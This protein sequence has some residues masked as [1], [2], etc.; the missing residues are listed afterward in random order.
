MDIDNA[1]PEPVTGTKEEGMMYH[2]EGGRKPYKTLRGAK[3]LAIDLSRGGR[4]TVRVFD[5]TGAVV[6]TTDQLP[7]VKVE[8]I[9]SSE[10][11]TR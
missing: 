4:T 6:W 1:K 10:E 9:S 3:S 7:V 5:D 2:V 8:F 11:G